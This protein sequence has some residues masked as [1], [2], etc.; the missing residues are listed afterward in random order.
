[1]VT[2][3]SLKSSTCVATVMPCTSA[4]VAMSAS[5]SLRVRISP[6]KS[7]LVQLGEHAGVEHLH[8]ERST[9][10]TPIV[11]RGGSNSMHATSGIASAS[12][13]LRHCLVSR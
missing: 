2:P 6:V 4:V 11:T 10:R 8:H 12:A 5:R 7:Y 9:G 3:E 13:M 1:M